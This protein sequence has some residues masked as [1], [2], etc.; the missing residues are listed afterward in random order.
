M[1]G[2]SRLYDYMISPVKRALLYDVVVVR[3]LTC[4]PSADSFCFPP[5]SRLT[6]FIHHFVCANLCPS[7]EVRI[8]ARHSS[9]AIRGGLSRAALTYKETFSDEDTVVTLL[10]VDGLKGK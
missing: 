8:Q 2:C 3:A 7:P 1:V 5:F 6:F 4:V 10:I 9:I